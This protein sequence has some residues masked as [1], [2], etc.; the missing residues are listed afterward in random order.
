M[1]INTAIPCLTT[2]W[3]TQNICWY[4]NRIQTGLVLYLIFNFFNFYFNFRFSEHDRCKV[5]RPL[6]FKVRLNNIIKWEHKQQQK[7]QKINIFSNIF[8]YL[9]YFTTSK[10]FQTKLIVGGV[11]KKKARPDKQVK[12]GGRWNKVRSTCTYSVFWPVCP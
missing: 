5:L 3:W 4:I 8:A 11:S 7:R 12:L 2:Y 6:K 10:D 1:F 9:M